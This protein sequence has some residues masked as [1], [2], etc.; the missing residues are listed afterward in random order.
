MLVLEEYSAI[1]PFPASPFPFLCGHAPLTLLS[2]FPSSYPPLPSP[3]FDQSLES[4]RLRGTP[5]VTAI[6]RSVSE[7]DG[8]RN[9]EHDCQTRNSSFVLRCSSNQYERQMAWL[10]IDFY[11]SVSFS[12]VCKLLSVSEYFLHFDKVVILFEITKLL[13]Y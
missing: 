5:N 8:G 12:R 11:S 9:V 3:R 1:L 13:R 6:S 7:E 10:N 2:P 4:S